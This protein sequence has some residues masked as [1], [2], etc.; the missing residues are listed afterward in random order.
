MEQSLVNFWSSGS[1]SNFCSYSRNKSPCTD[2]SVWE[3][4]LA[5]RK[6]SVSPLIPNFHLRRVSLHLMNLCLILYTNLLLFRSWLTEII[7]RRINSTVSSLPLKWIDFYPFSLLLNSP[8]SKAL[9]ARNT[10][11]PF[12][13]KLSIMPSV[14]LSRSPSGLWTWV[15][16]HFFS[17]PSPRNEQCPCVNLRAYSAVTLRAF[18]IQFEWFPGVHRIMVIVHWHEDDPPFELLRF[19]P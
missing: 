17:D 8:L 6:M 13:A 11:C 14:V 2:M 5:V 4:G 12:S 10:G 16:H 19:T 15:P 3:T 18:A 1:S 9:V 7:V